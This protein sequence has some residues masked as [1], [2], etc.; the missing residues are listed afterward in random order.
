MKEIQLLMAIASVRRLFQVPSVSVTRDWNAPAFR[1]ADR[2]SMHSS[3]ERGNE[4]EKYKSHV[5]N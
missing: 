5:M 1:D 2:Q 4:S 3:A